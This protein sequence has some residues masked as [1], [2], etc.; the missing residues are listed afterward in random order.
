MSVYGVA[1][2]E[3]RKVSNATDAVERI[4]GKYSKLLQLLA[5][6]T[7]EQAKYVPGLSLLVEQKGNT[8]T[9]TSFAG[10]T[11]IR[12]GWDASGEDLAGVAVFTSSKHGAIEPTVILRVYLPAW[13]GSAFLP[14]ESGNPV[15]MDSYRPG[16][17]AYEVLM[18][19]V[20]KQVDL[21]NI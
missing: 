2:A 4:N 13:N 8:A 19:V 5:Q 11:Q 10:E 9:L 7:S 15:L 3:W 18:N 20:R 17:F 14:L 6:T 16:D 1:D 21:S 12:L